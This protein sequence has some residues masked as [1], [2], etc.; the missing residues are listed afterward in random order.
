ML[1]RSSRARAVATIALALGFACT[2]A[3]EPIAIHE[4]T[5][6]LE[7]Q[8]SR[9][10]RNVTITVNDH[11]RGGAPSLAPGGR[12]TAPL[13]NF[14]TGFG[15]P[16]DLARMNVYRVRVTATD[17]DGRPVELAWGRP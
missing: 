4:G 11:F 6:V 2:P 16:F 9:E 13:R 8:S 3:R 5:L 15:H 14:Q 17:T 1:R 12:L 7:N 10:W